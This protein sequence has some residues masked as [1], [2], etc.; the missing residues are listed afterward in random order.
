MKV[1]ALLG[2]ARVLV[3]QTKYIEAIYRLKEAQVIND[4]PF[5]AQYINTLQDFVN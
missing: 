4:Q 3:K 1:E 5:I 2:S